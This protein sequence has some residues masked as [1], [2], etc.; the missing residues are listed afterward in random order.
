MLEGATSSPVQALQRGVL[1]LEDA[2]QNK[3]MVIKVIREHTG[4]GLKEAKDLCDGAPCVVAEWNDP[5][6]LQRFRE[7]L[8]RAGA[9]VR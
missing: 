6:R 4:A 7:A 5:A 9:R 3:I 1:R 2:G 8:A